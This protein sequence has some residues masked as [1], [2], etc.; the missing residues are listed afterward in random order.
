VTPEQ[1]ESIRIAAQERIRIA[2]Q[3]RI[4]YL[5]WLCDKI[6]DA[7]AWRARGLLQRNLIKE[8]RQLLGEIQ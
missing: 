2:A 1:R 5:L 6:E 8:V 3:E 4:A 7:N